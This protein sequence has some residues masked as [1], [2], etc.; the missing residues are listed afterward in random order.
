MLTEVRKIEAAYTGAPIMLVE[1]FPKRERRYVPA[2]FAADEE[3]QKHQWD[4]KWDQE[5][6]AVAK[7][8]VKVKD[9]AN[10]KMQVQIKAAELM[11]TLRQKGANPT[12]YSILPKLVEWC[13]ENNIRTE[14]KIIPSAGYLRTHVLGAKHWTP[15][16]V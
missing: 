10:W 9:V 1:I 13:H 8:G 11:T 3:G 2:A 15:P 4:Q 14:T 16:R 6:D 7:I 12:V 5:V